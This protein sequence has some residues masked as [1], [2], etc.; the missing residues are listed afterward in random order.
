MAKNDSSLNTDTGELDSKEK[1]SLFV[2]VDED[3]RAIIDKYK[4]MGI[5]IAKL[6]EDAV[7]IYDDFNSLSPEIKGIIDRYKDEGETLISFLER[8]I[9]YYGDQ[10]NVDRDLWVRAR[11]EMKMMLIGKTTFNQLI[12]AAEM[13]EDAR[14][15][16]YKKNVALDLILWYTKKPLKSL[17]IEEIIETI[18]KIWVVANYFY[19]IDVHKVDEKFHVLFKHR[20]NKR[21]S[22]YWIGYFTELFKSEDLACKCIVESQAFDETISMTIAYKKAK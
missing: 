6:I 19:Q 16:P 3:A 4:N 7:D 21:Y 12:H 5:K 10:K 17:E 15:R 20:Q 22:E 1:M 18:K 11:E 9:K 13:P 2:K 8:A 14:E